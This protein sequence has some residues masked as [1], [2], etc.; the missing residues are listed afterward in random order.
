MGNI[1]S[2]VSLTNRPEA[3]QQKA[4]TFRWGLSDSTD[5][6]SFGDFSLSRW[7]VLAEPQEWTQQQPGRGG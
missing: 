7:R 2:S 5:A 4:P 3:N 6:E 1:S